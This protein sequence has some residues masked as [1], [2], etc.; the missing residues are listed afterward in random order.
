MNDQRHE[1][2]VAAGARI[3]PATA[4]VWFEYGQVLDPYGELELSP[5]EECVGRMWFARDPVERIAVS[6]YD[7]SDAICEAL[8]DKQRAADEEGWAQIF[9]AAR[10][11]AGTR[12]STP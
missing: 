6:F 1:E 4:D 7:L 2:R 11:A 10:V 8:R 3:D 5:Q 9:S 12:N